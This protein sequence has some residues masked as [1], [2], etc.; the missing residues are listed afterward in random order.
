MVFIIRKG[1]TKVLS[2][3]RPGLEHLTLTISE[4]LP[5]PSYKAFVVTHLALPYI[6]I[7]TISWTSLRMHF[8]WGPFKKYRF[9]GPTH[10]YQ[11]ESPRSD[12]RICFVTSASQVIHVFRLSLGSKSL[13]IKYWQL[14]AAWVSGM[15]R[16]TVA[17]LAAHKISTYFVP[18]CFLTPYVDYLTRF[19]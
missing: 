14:L 4:S 10:A 18:G 6:T 12:L 17:A 19:S 9:L 13:V 7:P 16:K 2:P 8:T 15:D 1:I 3:V 11:S 5:H